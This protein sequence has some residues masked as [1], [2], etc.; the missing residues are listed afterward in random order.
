MPIAVPHREVSMS[1]ANYLARQTRAVTEHPA[2]Y[3]LGAT[4]FGFVGGD[5]LADQLSGWSFFFG[6]LSISLSGWFGFLL[7]R[8]VRQLREIKPVTSVEF[9]PAE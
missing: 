8:A 3:A 6:V 2:I 1:W 4:L 7:A 5:R 9:R